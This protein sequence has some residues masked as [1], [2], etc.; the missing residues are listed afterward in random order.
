MRKSNRRN[1][2]RPFEVCYTNKETDELIKVDDFRY[3]EFGQVVKDLCDETET[4]TEAGL[5]C[6]LCYAE[7]EHHLQVEEEKKLND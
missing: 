3:A 2:R 1:N 7:H 4:R 6:K 5:L